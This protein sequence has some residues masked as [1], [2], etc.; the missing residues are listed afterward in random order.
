MLSCMD[1][2]SGHEFDAFF[3]AGDR[4]AYSAAEQLAFVICGVERDRQVATSFWESAIGEDS[5]NDLENDE[6][7]RGFADAAMAVWNQVSDQL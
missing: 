5:Q 3:E 4:N 6:Y 2:T 7:V 1:R